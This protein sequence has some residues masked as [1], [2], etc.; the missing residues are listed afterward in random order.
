V[1]TLR[2]RIRDIR[3]STFEEIQRLA[4]SYRSEYEIAKQRQ[5]EMEKQ[6][7]EA[8]SHS[9][10]T[11]TA[12]VA[13]RELESRAK[14]YRDLYEAFLQKYTASQQESFPITEARLISPASPPTSKSKPKTV[15]VGAL[16]LMG[17]LGLGLGLA[18]FRELTDRVFRTAA[19]LQTAL[20]MPCLTSVPLLKG[21]ATLRP[22]LQLLSKPGS[23]NSVV[24]PR[25]IARDSSVYWEVVDCPLSPFAEAIRSIKLA[26]NVSVASRPNKVIGFT[27][28]VPN[29]GKSTVAAALAQLMAQ[30]GGRTIVVDCDLRNPSLSRSMAPKATVG[31]IDVISGVRSLEEA[32]WR[33]P[34]TDLVLLPS[35]NKSQLFHISDLL[36]AE[37]TK[38]LFDKLRA[39]FDHIIVDLPPLAPVVDV[40]AISHVMDCMILVVNW[41]QTRIDVVQ[42][43]LNSAPNVH[44]AVIGAVLNKTDMDHIGRYDAT[45]GDLYNNKYYAGSGPTS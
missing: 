19:Q 15:V 3:S 39:S 18:L 22:P 35:V 38:K 27:S 6:L 23:S 28:S 36:A 34:T 25:T 12:Q 37:S 40:R 5:Q 7:A 11:D 30:V 20:Q 43:A 13:L 14:S 1:V 17:G 4:Q 26:I 8:V 29:E 24:A 41:G 42:K 44:E 21:K 31:I 2:N 32:I 10:S 9:R 16:A 33:D 45:Y